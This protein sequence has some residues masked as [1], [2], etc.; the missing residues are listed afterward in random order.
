[1]EHVVWQVQMTVAKRLR[2]H[3]FGLFWLFLFRFRNNRIHGISILKKTLLCVPDL[4]TESEVTWELLYLRM[5]R[6]RRI[7]RQ[8]FPERTRFLFIPSKPHSFYS[9][10]SAIESRMN[11]MIFRSVRKQNSS[12]KNTNTVYSEYSYSRIVPK[13]RSLSVVQQHQSNL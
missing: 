3:S 10:H 2:L 4:E 6:P 7:S 1:M 11:G 9:V 5:R 12:Q 8:K 13:E